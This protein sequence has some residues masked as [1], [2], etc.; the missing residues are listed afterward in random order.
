M[1][2]LRF[3][4][5]L[6]FGLLPAFADTPKSG[7]VVV[8]TVS[9]SDKMLLP[10]AL[11]DVQRQTGVG[12]THTLGKDPPDV[13]LNL[14]KASFWRAVDAIAVA[15]NAKAVQSGR[16][17][18]VVLQPFTK[19]DRRPP[20][21]YD[22]PFRVRVTRINVSR[23][24]E[25]DR[26]FCAVSLDVTWTPTLRPL[27]LESQAQQVKMRDGDGNDV[28]VDAEGSSLAPVD[29]RFN[30]PLELSLPALP[31][32]QKKI[33]SL[34][35][36]LIAVAPTKMIRFAFDDDLSSLSDALPGGERR[37]RSQD[38]VVCQVA[39]VVLGRESWSVQMTLDYPEGN[40]KL[41]S[42]Q[43]SSLVANNELLLT[44]RDGKR[45]LAP[46][47]SVI[48]QVG[49]RRAVVTYHFTDKQGA[50]RG[51]AGDWRLAYVAPARVVE[52]M[53]RFAFKDLR[54]P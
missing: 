50:P 11:K 14:D 42:F 41:E 2:H 3:A 9:L 45:K 39:K 20:A 21:S 43:L 52:V 32:A 47:S 35:G 36:K 29:G 22:G 28:P 38:E 10:Q 54:L 37:R 16:D 17:G 46:S 19:D 30:L 34:E 26:G 13:S 7:D 40:R 4:A 5:L 51:K 23:D 49:S 18:S 15:T 25:S 6:V 12:L 1:P 27:F 31:R 48:D 8:P 53:F 33:G 44:S 24:F